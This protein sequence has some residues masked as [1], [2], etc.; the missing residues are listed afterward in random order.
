MATPSM[1]RIS[2]N[3]GHSRTIDD[4]RV[5]RAAASSDALMSGLRDH[6]SARAPMA[7]ID[8]ARQPVVT[9]SARL[10]AAALMWNARVKIGSSGCTAYIRRKTEKPAENTARLIFQKAAEPRLTC[11]GCDGCDGATVRWC[12]GAGAGATVRWCDGSTVR[13]STRISVAPARGECRAP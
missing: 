6:P 5:R 9:D 4:S 8:T 1:A 3:I 2:R 10:L 13:G 12:D 11:D 7:S